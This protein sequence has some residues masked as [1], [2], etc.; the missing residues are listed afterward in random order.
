M[1]GTTMK[2]KKKI[3]IL[4]VSAFI[5]IGV[6]GIGIDLLIK[7]QLNNVENYLT[8]NG[9]EVEEV[10]FDDN[11]FHITLKINS[12]EDEIVTTTS[13]QTKLMYDMQEESIYFNCP[14]ILRF[15]IS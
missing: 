1:G 15:V 11:T 6:G 4:I 3:I 14:M 8:Q 2:K 12:Y 5:L 9:Y 10:S 7:K 13:K